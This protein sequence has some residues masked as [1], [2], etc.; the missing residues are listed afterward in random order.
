MHI[1]N[2]DKPMFHLKKKVFNQ[3]KDLFDKLNNYV[4]EV[5]AKKKGLSLKEKGNRKELEKYL[6]K[7]DYFDS[8]GLAEDENV[9]IIIKKG[10]EKEIADRVEQIM[11][12]YLNGVEKYIPEKYYSFFFG[13]E[14]QSFMQKLKSSEEHPNSHI[15]PVEMKSIWLVQEIVPMDGSENK[16]IVSKIDEMFTTLR[17]TSRPASAS[18]LARMRIGSD[19]ARRMRNGA[20]RCT[21]SI[22]WNCSSVI[23]WIVAS[24]V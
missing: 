24:Q 9:K 2:Y 6:T 7:V 21:S 13:K 1:L 19:A 11:L 14:G 17:N 10:E 5:I 12:N 20:T 3:C 23:F 15:T 22:D 8:E 16:M 4:E 18:F